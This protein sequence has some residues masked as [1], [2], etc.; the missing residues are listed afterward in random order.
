MFKS[1]VGLCRCIIDPHRN[2]EKSWEV[3]H[4]RRWRSWKFLKISGQN[5]PF[6]K[7]DWNGFFAYIH[8]EPKLVP[9][10]LLGRLALFWRGWVPSKIEVT[11]GVPGIYKYIRIV[12][13]WKLGFHQWSGWS[14]WVFEK[15]PKKNPNLRSGGHP[16]GMSL[17][18]LYP[19]LK[20]KNRWQRDILG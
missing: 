8:L 9:L 4:H 7:I 5:I 13:P 20:A 19:N 17:D 16:W 18:L 2:P 12:Q 15:S 11:I 6:G 14:S 10:V 3:H 1:Y